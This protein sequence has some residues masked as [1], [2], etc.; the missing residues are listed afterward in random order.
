MN[1]NYTHGNK[2]KYIVS[3]Y[4]WNVEDHYYCDTY[5]GA[6]R[7]FDSIKG[8]KHESGT[9]LTIADA[10]KYVRKEFIKF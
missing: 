9:T 2:T 10:V 8:K 5:K 3:L 6:K 1:F 7:I 4:G